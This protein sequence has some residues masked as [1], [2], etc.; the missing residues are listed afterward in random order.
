[1]DMQLFGHHCFPHLPLPI[2]VRDCCD[3]PEVLFADGVGAGGGEGE[4]EEGFL[5]VGGEGEEVHNLGDAGA[6]DVAE[7]GEVGE[8]LCLSGNVSIRPS[9]PRRR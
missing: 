1:M 5:D 2:P 8:A 3:G 7:T 6:G 9:T 4:R